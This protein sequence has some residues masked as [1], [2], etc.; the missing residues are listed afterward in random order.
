MNRIGVIGTMVWDT[1]HGRHPGSAPVEEW[2]GIGY[3]LA[4]L[5]ATLP[6]N[7]EIVPLIKV[8]SDLAGKANEFLSN[9]TRRGG[10]ARFVEVP[11]P[12]NRVTLRYDQ[13]RR[14]A[15]RLTGGVPP[16]TWE[17]LGPMVR[18]VDVL[19]VNFISGF[20]LRLE[21]AQSLR[22]AFPGPIYAD[23]HSLFLGVR[24][25]GLRTPKVLPDVRAWFA[26]FDAV[27]LNEDEMDLVGGEPM[28]VAAQA[29][30]SG[31]GL[32]IVTLAER[33]A[34]YFSVPE[35]SF[36]RMDARARHST[37]PICSELVVA[38]RV[39][40]PVDPTGC[41]DVFGATVVSFLA[42]GSGVTDAIR[43]ANR[44]AASNLTHRGATHLHRHLRGQLLVQ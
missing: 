38:E 43:M 37:G 17:E 29:L 24:A 19:Y 28:E 6:E 31:V 18:D 42:Q 41:G 5:D 30:G 2:G 9:L 27:Q 7:W 4:A 34:V 40:E 8:G 15:E 26:C 11:A 25:D 13:L 3:A 22:Q 33:G 21:T 23:L 44:N 39:A 12:N 10:S 14:T 1:I 16:W 20:E 32:L 36:E 35:Y